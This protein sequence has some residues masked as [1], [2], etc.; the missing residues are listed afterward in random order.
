MNKSIEFVTGLFDRLL[1]QPVRNVKLGYGSFLTM[2][3]GKD[4][5]TEIIVRKKKEIDIRP[6]WYLWVYMCSWRL[7]KNH[8]ILANSDDKRENIEGSL[9]YLENKKLLKT[10]VLSDHCDMRLE[11]ED[12]I[13]LFLLSDNSEDDNE[14]WMLFTPDDMVLVAGPNQ[15]ISYHSASESS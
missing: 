3:F 1:K 15:K 9:K 8:E 5:Q 2:G 6:E 13:V 7:E 11:F 4:L 12:G 14:Q 10:E